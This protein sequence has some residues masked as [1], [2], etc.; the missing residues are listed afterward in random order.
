MDVY[1]Q[2]AEIVGIVR[3]GNGTAKALC[4]RKD[5]Q[6]KK[7]TYA[8]VCETLRHYELLE[9]VL[10]VAEFFKYYPQ[11]NHEFAMCMAYDV[12]LG[13]GVNT[14]N[15]S[16]ARAVSHSASYLREAYW[17]V[18]K[19]HVIPPRSS[20]KLDD[21]VAADTEGGAR[22]KRRSGDSVSSS[23]SLQLPRYARVNTLKISVEELVSRLR[24]SAEVRKRARDAK[25]N[26]GDAAASSHPQQQNGDKRATRRA[27]SRPHRPLP[28]F[29]QDPVV[30]HLLVFPP[31]TDLHAHPAVRS[32]QLILQDRA[33]CLPAAVLLD[34][35]P[36]EVIEGDTAG[37]SKGRKKAKGGTALGKEKG[38]G[39]E[40]DAAA[41]RPLEYVVDACAAPGN[42]TT[43]LAALGAPHIKIMATERDERR[44]DL[45]SKRV[46][47]LGAADYVNVVSMDFFQLSSDDRAATEGIL[48]DPSCSASGVM[49]RVDVALQHH[50][51]H[52]HEQQ[53]KGKARQADRRVSLLQGSRRG[54]HH[55]DAD[56]NAAEEGQLDDGDREETANSGAINPAA[57]GN[58]F[59]MKEERVEKLARLQRKLLAH[60]LLSFD[61]CRTVV[62]STCSVHEEENEEVVRQVL[63]DERVKARGWRLSNIM[64]NTWKTRGAERE[65]EEHPLRFTIRCDPATEATNGFY[66]ARFDR[67]C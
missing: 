29:T 10:E 27:S 36:V 14:H 62:Y 56:R 31:G 22:G 49:T 60:S 51:H 45:L 55:E 18:R 54:S 32:G 40:T 26:D 50:H 20:E 11:A 17:Q 66:V 46:A 37:S 48:L 6:K 30:P 35:V 47:S 12:V 67:V 24:R 28:E 33:S 19:H 39:N 38:R 25:D 23:P 2:A 52:H 16:T 42:K 5:M 7:Q 57:Q 61:N 1:R 4:L 3:E 59:S 41:R 63:D 15:D 43:Q 9:D 64:P 8:V 21:E 65:G 44:A 13:K 34:A 58:E 53:R